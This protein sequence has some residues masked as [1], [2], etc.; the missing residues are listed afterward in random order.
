MLKEITVTAIEEVVTIDSPRGRRVE[1]RDRWCYGLSFCESGRITYFHKGR[2][3]VSEPGQAVLLPA[4]EDYSLYCSEAG[5]F[6][7]INFSCAQPLPGELCSVALRRPESYL[8]EYR[9]LRQIHLLHRDP[10]RCMSILYGMFSDLAAE[11]RSESPVLAPALEWMEENLFDPQLNNTAL[12]EKAGVSEVYFRRLFRQ[13]YGTTPRQYILD[14]RLHRARQLLAET[15]LPVGEVSA[16]CG[17]VSLYHFSRA[18]RAAVGMPPSEY[19]T[20]AGRRA[21]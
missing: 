21:L 14:T 7:V 4:G 17:F 13:A 18:F 11:Q 10:A 12:A 16:Q 19:R 9:R 1:I 15:C 6:P 20:Q 8:R 2:A 5:R 3:T